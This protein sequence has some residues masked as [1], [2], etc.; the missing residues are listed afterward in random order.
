VRAGL[1]AAVCLV[2]LALPQSAA[3]HA[4]LV[5]TTPERGAQVDAA[6]GQVAFRFNE[7]VEAGFGAVRVFDAEGDRVDEG[8]LIRPGDG[9]EAVGV[10]LR[11]DLPDGSYTAT[12]R[13][14][15]ADSHPIAGGFVFTVGHGG[16]APSATVAE[17]IEE[18]D[19][20]PA[21]SI[22]FGAVR[23]LA[24]LAIALAVGGV[25]FLGAVWLPGLRAA[26]GAEPDWA[27]ASQAFAARFGRMA[28]VTVVLGV[29]TT[30]FGIVLQGANAGG[31]SF[32]SALDPTV[33]GDVLGTRFGTVWGLRFLDWLLLGVALLAA[34]AGARLPVLRP[35]SLGAAGLAAT[36]LASARMLAALALL[37]GFLVVS[38]GLSGH[39]GT[40]DPELVVMTSDTLHVL[41]MSVW[42]GGLVALLVVLP[43]ATRR[44]EAPDRTRLLAACLSRFSPLALACVI[45][46]I[47]SGTF[48]SI[49]YL[50]ALGDLT[51]SAFGRAI[52]V[53]IALILVLIGLG[54]LNMRRNRPQLERLAAEGAAP[55]GAGRLLRRAVQAE[56]GLIVVVLGVTAA[57][58]SY[59]PPG[60]EAAG[61]FTTSSELGPAELEVTV[62]PA[63]AGTNEI[64]LYLF[65]ARDGSQY[66]R[67]RELT[68][69]LRLP[70][71]DIGPLE[72]RIDKAGPGHY[73][74]RR[75]LIAPA[76]DWQ[77]LVRARVSEFE[78]HRAR[79]EVPVE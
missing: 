68:V 22:A 41:A 70:D 51:D 59:P 67:A 37:L 24:Y 40:T 18:G 33:I 15:S 49:L 77:L 71:R 20:G 8:E 1:F 78:E 66:D 62:D 30:A 74:A 39:A 53:K 25:V 10:A 13:V 79:V 43:A 2:A 19:A 48:Q 36:R 57:L 17:L 58:T 46:L 55:G 12:Y 9:S 63:D 73:V 27:S 72:S 6:P 31:T 21:T 45:V 65:D 32:W 60:A 61:P 69:Q 11:G 34:V 54:A 7:P 3:A 52:L 26:S 76:G 42:M 23:A 56:V 64:H 4:E 50:E 38:P 29:L 47:G 28:A 44:V 35:A 75:A 16:A 14:V 5:S